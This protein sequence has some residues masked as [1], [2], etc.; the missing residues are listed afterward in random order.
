MT[1]QTTEATDRL[2]Q[3]DMS[4]VSLWVANVERAARFYGD[5]LGWQYAEPVAGPYRQVD[6]LSVSQGL[7][8]LKGS[9]DFL[10]SMGVPLASEP[11]ATAYVVFVVDDVHAAAER[12]RAAGGFATEP[13]EQPYGLVSACTDDQGLVFSIHEVPAGAP[14]PRSP[15]T[16]A[17][18]G[19]VAYVVFEEPDSARA[20][21]FFTSVLGVRFEPGR[22]PDGWNVP[23]TAPMSGFAGGA[24]R[25][26]VVP[27]YRVDDIQAAVARVRAAGGVASEP[28]HEGYGIRAECTDDQGLRFH[29][30][31][32]PTR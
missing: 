10:R 19:D 13:K 11:A 31:Q 30:G 12:V 24:A 1:L 3:G 7:T 4:Y 5:V 28:R 8:E 32:L 17:R 14:A 23:E 15:A 9:G 21:T 6:G 26:T 29:L 22:A 2:R 20:R 25:P 18:Q 27:M 16:G